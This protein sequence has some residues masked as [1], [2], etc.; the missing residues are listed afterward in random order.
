MCHNSAILIQDN[1]YVE[2]PVITE[3]AAVS[4]GV[5]VV[6]EYAVDEFNVITKPAVDESIIVPKVCF[7]IIVFECVI[8][9]S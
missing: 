1:E 5:A 2:N 6:N 9:V 8:M 7:F 4:E 3:A